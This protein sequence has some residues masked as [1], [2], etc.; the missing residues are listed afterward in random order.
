ML[1]KIDL[2]HEMFGIASEK[3]ATCDHLVRCEANRVYYKCE[4]Y[5]NT[6]SEATDW[7]KSY[8]S[9]GLYNKPYNGTPIIEVKKHF[10]R[11]EGEEQIEGQLSLFEG[12]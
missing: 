4:C 11:K 10:P 8:R 2:M 12:E 9:C 6:D 5:G 7:R 3:C 1:K